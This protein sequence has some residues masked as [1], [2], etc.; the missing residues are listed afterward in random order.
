MNATFLCCIASGMHEGESRERRRLSHVLDVSFA[1]H[2]V[3]SNYIS[4]NTL[5]DVAAKPFEDM[6]LR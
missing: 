4:I 1:R 3:H 2:D 5:L 6:K